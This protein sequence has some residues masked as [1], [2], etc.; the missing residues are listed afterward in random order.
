M[1]IKS[2]LRLITILPTLI[3]VAA[4]TYLFYD[5]Y[6]N[7]E[8]IK[9]Y[10]IIT[11]NNKYID[12]L[13][14]ETGRERGIVALYLASNKSS[15]KELLD[16]QFQ[17]T[18]RAIKEYKENLII[19]NNTILPKDYLFNE[20]IN[21]DKSDYYSLNKKLT[22]LNS[23]RSSINSANA[24]NYQEVLDSYSKNLT[25]PTLKTLLKINKFS[26]NVDINKIS[27]TLTNLYI[28][29]EYAGL[30]RDFLIFNIEEKRKIE[31]GDIDKWI[32]YHTKAMLFD[33]KLID[34]KELSQKVQNY[35]KNS[36]SST[37][38]EKFIDVYYDIIENAN[39]GNYK[40]D[41]IRLFTVLSKYVSLHD[42]TS[43]VI[44]QNAKDEIAN[45]SNKYLM[46]V[47]L[48]AFLLLI[49]LLLI[50]FG[51]R[52]SK[53]LDSNSKELE[54]SLKRAVKRI[55]ETD[56]TVKDE[57][58]EINSIDFETSEGMKRGYNFLENM[59]ETAKED[60][61]EAIEAN[62]AKSYFLANMSHEIRT[63]MNGIIGFAELLK[64]TNL[65]DEQ[66]EYVQI[67]EKSSDNLL[68]IIN[69][70][71]DL[72]KLESNRVELEHVIFDT[73]KEFDSAV[74]T[75]AVIASD[76]NIELN[77]FLDPEISPKLKGDPTKLKEILT[78]LLNNA[79]KFTESGGE[80]DIEIKKSFKVQNDNRV[81]IEF[82]VND[83]GIGMSKQQLERIFQPFMQGDSS[84]NRK[85]GGTGLGLTI[86]KQY[87]EL[88]GGELK[89][90]SKENVGSTFYFT[91]PI[92]EIESATTEYK[93]KF[94]DLTMLIYQD[95]KESKLSNFITKYLKY[96][97][98]KYETFNGAV[99]LNKLLDQYSGKGKKAV[100]LDIDIDYD[101]LLDILPIINNDELI[102]TTKVTNN[103]SLNNFSLPNERVLFKPI[104]FN[105]FLST[106]KYLI[107][108]EEAPEEET[109]TVHAKY[110]GKAL[111]AEDNLINQKLIVNILKGFG[112]SID[113]ADNGQ[114][115]VNKR[116]ANNDYD[117]VFMDIQM[118]IMDG[119]E[120]TKIIKKYEDEEGLDSVPVIALT[121][122]ALKGD[123]E[124]LLKEGLDEYISKPIEMSEL[125][126]IL[127]KFLSHKSSI[128]LEVINKHSK[129]QE[130]KQEPAVEKT[131]NE[132]PKQQE[133][134]K[135]TPKKILIAKK[136]PLSNKILST[137]MASIEVAFDV[138]EDSENLAHKIAQESYDIIFTDEEYLTKTIAEIIKKENIS[139]V[140]TEEPQDSKE[141]AELTIKYIKQLT[142]KEEIV[143]IID[144]IRNN[145]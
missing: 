74:D 84:I 64:G 65:N 60:K 38:K 87:I 36:Y 132:A 53:E 29:Q 10:K 117:L 69:N 32:Y 14:I 18:N 70:I 121:A 61:V 134:K 137:L 77:Y 8:K 123:R 91:L 24:S 56:P 113:V 135:D 116:K 108:F 46:L 59:I 12:N 40:T 128:N 50:L 66:R 104:G 78:N 13:L 124:R 131:L 100:L 75:F 122:N 133:D 35:L 98:V 112:L 1:K 47:A 93:D 105:K 139:I 120:A 19:E 42:K 118:P 92:E 43:A 97:G 106:L 55:G 127:H 109:P 15:Y 103:D 83:S 16:K 89:V 17:K 115:A 144:D 96:Y 72:S 58:D 71:L 79:I 130:P 142:S 34:N 4:A 67:I 11:K 76:K 2:K 141:Y 95:A 33:P 48:F 81:W 85:Y 51:N 138:I 82:I 102:V 73:A 22:A 145:K 45:Y 143:S 20:P 62:K 125:L 5:T 23:I 114:E 57:L 21:I 30:L 7:Y 52:L 54:K 129:K 140:L 6:I 31:K 99:T 26:L 49:S 68:D 27:N 3:L 94:S 111:V 86:T 136:F 101:K 37:I 39:T 107:K 119:I 25:T 44:Y 126:Y 28:S 9:A 41:T 88:L 80:I 110:F 90:E 63:P